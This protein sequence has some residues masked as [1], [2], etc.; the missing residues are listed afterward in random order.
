MTT[1]ISP[2]GTALSSKKLE[3]LAMMLK[4]KGISA[5][6]APAIR[7]RSGYSP[8]PLSFAQRRLWF[9]DQLDP[10]SAVYNIP[11]AVRITGRL[12]VPALERSFNELVSRHESLRTTFRTS[13][14]QPEQVISESQPFSLL[15]I[16]LTAVPENEGGRETERLLQVA[17]QQP[18]DLANGPLMHSELLRLN[19]EDHV[20]LLTMHHIVSDGWSMR[21]LLQELATY[22]AAFSE[23]KS[24]SLAELPI[25]YADYAVWQREWLHGEVL[26]KQIRYWKQQLGGVLPVLELPT[27]HPRPIVQTYRGAHEP[28]TL[29][30]EVSESLKQISQ[31]NGSTLFMTLL[32]AFKVLLCRYS[33]QDEVIVGMP[34]AGRHRPEL[35]GL[36]G[37]FI[38]TLVLRTD[39]SGKPSFQ[40]VIERVRATA[41]GAYEH[42]DLPFEELVDTL[43]PERDPGRTPLFQVMFTFENAAAMKLDLEGLQFEPLSTESATAKFDLA[44]SMTEGERGLFGTLDYNTDLF[45]AST[46]RRMAE[47][48]NLLLEGLTHNPDKCVLD[49]P[50]LTPSEHQQLV[51][52]N[53]TRREYPEGCIQQVF[54]AQAART[55]EAVA[56]VFRAEQVSY[57]ELNGRA[58][59]LAH[60]LRERG[61]GSEVLVGVMLERGV[62]MIVTLLAILKAG[63]GYLPLDAQYPAQRLALMLSD[64]ALTVLVTEEQFV[65][66]LPAMGTTQVISLEGERAAIE[67]ASEEN[68]E[69]WTGAE[70]LAY[71]IY[72][73]GSTG[74]PKGVS[75]SHSA[76]IRL[77]KENDFVNFGA[78]EVFLQLAPISFDASTFELWG[79]LLNGAKLIIMPPQIPSLAELGEALVRHQVTTLW[80]TAGLFHLMVDEQLA[81]LLVVRQLLAGGDV[82]SVSHVERFL[83]AASE[84]VLINGYGPTENTTFSCTYRMSAGQQLRDSSVPIGRPI[85][86]TQVYVLDLNLAPVPIG[87]LGHL[88]LAGA[89]LARGYLRRPDLTAEQFLPHPY[90]TVPGARLYRTGDLVRWQADG[91]IEFWGRRDQQVKLRGFRIELGEIEAV[92][93]HHPAVR[94]VV[95]LARED[96][97]GDKRLVAY[98]ITAPGTADEVNQWRTFLSEKLPDYM[99]PAAFISL[100]EFPLTPNGKLDRDA[101]P[102]PDAGRPEQGQAYLGPRDEVERLL[103]EMWQ[104][105]LG[106]EQVGVRDNFFDLGGDS[107][108][109]AILINQ[110]QGMLGEYVYVVAIF[111]APTVERLGEYVRRHYPAAVNRICGFPTPAPAAVTTRI[112]ADQMAKFKQLIRASPAPPAD[113]PA[114]LPE[115]PGDL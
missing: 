114:A 73:S 25:Q 94:D 5:S 101:L 62:E 26:E 52:W 36:V 66:A 91:Q 32:A 39:L 98:L 74:I 88:Y 7:R 70:N 11:L 89:G 99:I 38:N 68:P 64:A 82:L 19:P 87:V 2:P 93:S 65:A 24:P 77:V 51:E 55:P 86:N 96:V 76:V 14:D 84:S 54:E 110:L 105:V 63:G 35:E 67:Q 43:Q 75:V 115:S 85:A 59:Q 95:V 103:V 57:K 78:A 37:F 9:L 79:S 107:I 18:F 1:E 20:L 102:A 13:N 6:A 47:H 40:Q 60:Y 33:G 46:I 44:L 58:N 90:S 97:A 22:Y 81:D 83:A 28:L 27:D 61:V 80:L 113:A 56:L 71:V 23:S 8:A 10:N 109:G 3:L 16:D 45:E 92:L 50:L 100:A 42:Q 112:N 17:L 69:Q 41:L 111:D 15:V 30:K 104:G 31:Q 53:E 49:L 106:V 108:K 4:K 29:S 48:F 72:T 12:N 34:I 21:V